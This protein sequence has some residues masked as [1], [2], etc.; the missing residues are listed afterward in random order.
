LEHR[1]K[2]L[3][4]GALT[5]V[6]RPKKPDAMKNGRKLHNEAL[7]DF[8]S[9]TDHISLLKSRRMKLAYWTKAQSVFVEKGKFHS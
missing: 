8:Y 2:G 5:K 7:R 9:L 1:I 3:Q 4:D 6:F